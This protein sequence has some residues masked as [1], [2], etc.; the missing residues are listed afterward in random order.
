LFDR[1]GDAETCATQRLA[2]T[3]RLARVTAGGRETAALS[4]GF[5]IVAG[6]GDEWEGKEI[7][8]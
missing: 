5:E 6:D 4:C 7:R 8:L 1:L 2:D 3:E